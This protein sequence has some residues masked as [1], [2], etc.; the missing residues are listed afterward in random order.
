MN[1]QDDYELILHGDHTHTIE[2]VVNA[3]SSVRRIISRLK[4]EFGIKC[5]PQLVPQ[6]PRRQAFDTTMTVSREGSGVLLRGN[7]ETLSKVSS[8]KIQIVND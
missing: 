1:Q 2:F 7:Q 5:H 4:I 3:I 8:S 6:C